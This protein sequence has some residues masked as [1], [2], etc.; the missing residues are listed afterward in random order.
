ML[1]AVG[2]YDLRLSETEFWGLVPRQFIALAERAKDERIRSEYGPA[3]IVTAILAGSGAKAS[4]L[5]PSIY[6]PSYD[7]N[8]HG[9]SVEEQKA[10]LR[11]AMVA[12]GGRP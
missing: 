1:W 10:R 2:R 4:R 7:E 5:K 12:V 11:A 8:S 9:P 6:M 3:I